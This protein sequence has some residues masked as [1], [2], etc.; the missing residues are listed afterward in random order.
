MFAVVLVHLLTR[1]ERLTIPRLGGVLAGAFGVAAMIGPIALDGLGVN[2][3]AQVAVLGAAISY[4]CAGIHGRR[5]R[6]VPPLVTAT[7]Q[8]TATTIMMVPL[9]FTVDRIWTL[10]AP[11]VLIWA[12]VISLALLGTALGYVIYFRI[13][14]MAG[15]TNLLLV[16]FLI[17]VSAMVLAIVILGERPEPRHVVGMA[18]IGLGLAVIDGRLMARCGALR[19]GNQMP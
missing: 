9:V 19:R 5:F 14:A 4:A 7:G 15:A 13:L 6:N 2:L 18:L 3:T 10:P 17:P 1:D 8:L 11:G 16:T 12:A